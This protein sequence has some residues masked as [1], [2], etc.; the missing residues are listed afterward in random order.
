MGIKTSD[1]GDDK[2][3]IFWVW[4]VWAVGFS[5]I[6]DNF[7]SL[8]QLGKATAFPKKFP[9]TFNRFFQYCS[10]LIW[11]N[12]SWSV[13]KIRSILPSDDCLSNLFISDPDLKIDVDLKREE[14]EKNG[15]REYGDLE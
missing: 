10:V 6:L 1:T 7:P 5:G 13:L 2:L 11:S 9:T 4:T 12:P 15:R 14:E 3:N 8:L